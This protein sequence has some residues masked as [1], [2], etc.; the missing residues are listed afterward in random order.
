MKNYGTQVLE[1]FLL[2]IWSRLL[3]QCKIIIY[4]FEEKCLYLA[5]IHTNN[6]RATKFEKVQIHFLSDDFFFFCVM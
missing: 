1:L 4:N 6:I 5:Y 3:A 2:F